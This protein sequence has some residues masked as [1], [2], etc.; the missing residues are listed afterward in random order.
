MLVTNWLVL[1]ATFGTCRCLA[2]NVSTV[3]GVRPAD[4]SVY[5]DE[6][7]SL[8]CVTATKIKM[9]VFG[10]NFDNDT[11]VAFSQTK[12]ADGSCTR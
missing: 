7:G 9:V 12:N 2:D 10:V 4:E 8:A 6:S 3:F 5:I 11:R 1:V